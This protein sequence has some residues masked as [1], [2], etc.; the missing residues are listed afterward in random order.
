MCSDFTD[1]LV[2]FSLCLPGTGLQPE[3]SA[4]WDRPAAFEQ[5]QALSLVT[6]LRRSGETVNS[7]TSEI[8]HIT[9]AFNVVSIFIAKGSTLLV[10]LVSM[11][12]CLGS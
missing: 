8:Y 11:F 9:L 12:C 2:T 5:L 4:F 3:N 6:S 1:D 10:Y 7:L